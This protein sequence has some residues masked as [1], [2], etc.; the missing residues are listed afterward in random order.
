[1]ETQAAA[2]IGHNQPP[3]PTPYEKVRDEI[4]ELYTEA[5]GWLDGVAIET[6]GQADGV[7][8]LINLIRDARKTADES[9]KLENEP[10]DTGK[11]EVQARYNPLLKRCDLAV[12]ACKKAIAPWLEKEKAAK[13]AIAAKA[14]AEAEEKQRIAEAAIRKASLDNLAEREKA[15]A[16]LKD[17]KKAETEAKRAERDTAKAGMGIGRATSLRTTWRPV[18]TDPLAAIRHY[19]VQDQKAVALFLLTLAESDVR[20][21]KREIPGF[22]VIEERVAV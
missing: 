20:N 22:S 7:S 10:Y 11:A 12:D 9:R 4:E 3:E 15:E 13:E 19:W 14:R 17:A 21:G 18:M 1:M 8:T 16:L 2:T 6:K 5:A